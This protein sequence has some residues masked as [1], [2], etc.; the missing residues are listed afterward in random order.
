MRNLSI[1]Y[2]CG[3]PKCPTSEAPSIRSS[4]CRWWRRSQRQRSRDQRTA[5]RPRRRCRRRIRRT[6]RCRRHDNR[7]HLHQIPERG[8]GGR[9]GPVRLIVH[10]VIQH[11]PTRMRR[12]SRRNRAIALGRR[13]IR[14]RDEPNETRRARGPSNGRLRERPLRVARCPRRRGAREPPRPMTA[15][16][17]GSPR[18]ARDRLGLVGPRFRWWSPRRMRNLS[19]AASRRTATPQRSTRIASVRSFRTTSTTSRWPRWNSWTGSCICAPLRT[20]CIMPAPTRATTRCA[21]WTQTS[22]WSSTSRA[23]S[24]DGW[25]GRSRKSNGDCWKRSGRTRWCAA[26]HPASKRSSS[27]RR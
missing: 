18:A 10:R 23:T 22:R 21:R 8:P 24:S 6:C 2:D 9:N 3:S 19:K 25:T 15:M 16:A 12:Q 14:Q 17:E 27:R 7:R 11:L 4:A 26:T 1:T 5:T 13:R 20:Q